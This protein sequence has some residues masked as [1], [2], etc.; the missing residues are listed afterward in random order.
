MSQENFN[1]IYKK[2]IENV[3]DKETLSI[4]MSLSEKEKIDRFSK[5]IDFGTAGIR[6]EIK[7]GTKYINKYTISKFAYCF[8]L[9]LKE[10][11]SN[12]KDGLVIFHDNRKYG[13][14]FSFTAAK[15]L[16][17]FGIPVFLYKNNEPLVTPFL[18]YLI[19]EKKLL[20]GINVT[21]SHNTKEYS[22]MKFYDSFGKQI[23][24]DF[25]NLFKKHLNNIDDYFN[26]KMNED[27]IY[28]LDDFFIYKYIDD[29]F[30]FLKPPLEK[31]HNFK[32]IYNSNH[33]AGITITKPILE[34]LK[35]DF[36]IVNEQSN[37]DEEFSNSKNPN[38]QFED[39]FYFSKIYGNK[40]NADILIG[41]DPDADRIGV[42]V[43]NGGNWRL[44]NGNELPII[45]L[46]YLL[47]NIKRKK[48]NLKNT[49]TVN[50]IVTSKYLDKMLEKYN[51]KHYS[52][53]TGFANI[54]EKVKEIL[55]EN[56]HSKLLFAWEESNGSIFNYDI[57]RDKDF[58][59]SLISVIEIAYEMKGKYNKT[60]IDYLDDIKKEYGYFHT[61]LRIINLEKSNENYSNL[62][63]KL[64][65]K[66]KNKDFINID[67]IEI[68]DYKNGYKDIPKSDVTEFIFSDG[69]NILIRNSGTEPIL[70]IYINLMSNI[71]DK[72]DILFS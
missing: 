62:I 32:I 53:I 45:Q 16:S 7:S 61:E 13:R 41:S 33:G 52:T 3:E 60:L 70:K 10:S 18:S 8:G 48:I 31:K 9:T 68:R 49:F 21:A 56:K 69:S 47:K 5:E 59:Q 12:L 38:P 37:F 23:G 22:G 4:L 71:R 30:N 20:G 57:T 66:L 36:A 58:F 55:E 51:V 19:I 43:R 42:M 11:K 34:K 65:N 46:H 54:S 14:L 44:L 35:V 26:F 17:A 64:I 6:G 50:S 2:W 63:N 39:S 24:K 25:I 29:L 27:N 28:Y 40:F 67:L 1:I 15:I 72:L